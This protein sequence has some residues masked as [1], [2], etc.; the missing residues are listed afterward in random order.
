MM[1]ELAE[2]FRFHGDGKG[3]KNMEVLVHF[4][5]TDL[6]NFAAEAL[7]H[8]VIIKGKRLVALIHLQVEHDQILTQKY[9]LLM[10][11]SKH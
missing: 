9:H 6:Y 8:A 10:L 2:D 5:G 1:M 11:Y 7:L 4:C 3:I